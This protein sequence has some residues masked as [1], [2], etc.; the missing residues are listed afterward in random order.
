MLDV[1]WML[2]P[3]PFSGLLLYSYRSGV[4]RAA[5][6]RHLREIAEQMGVEVASYDAA[7][8]GNMW[9]VPALLDELRICDLTSAETQPTAEELLSL[10]V[11]RPAAPTVIMAPASSKH[12]RKGSNFLHVEEPR[13]TS[14]NLAKVM[15]YLA[16]TS[17]LTT[18]DLA[19][20]QEVLFGHFRRWI[21]EQ[22]HVP[23][24]EVMQEYDHAVVQ[25]SIPH[26]GEKGVGGGGFA[27]AGRSYL[28]GSLQC[29]LASDET[30]ALSQLLRALAMRK[31]RGAKD[32]DVV[33]QLLK[34]SIRVQEISCCGGRRWSGRSGAWSSASVASEVSLL[35]SVLLLRWS[36]ACTSNRTDPA[37]M[38]LLV[39]FDHFCRDF[40]NRLQDLA[41]DPLT[42]CWTGIRDAFRAISVIDESE[43]PDPAK[44]LLRSVSRHAV[45]RQPYPWIE[46][47]HRTVGRAESYRIPATSN[48]A[49]ADSDSL[50]TE[51]ASLSEVM[52]QK[53]IIQE[54]RDRFQS[55]RHDRPLLLAGPGGSGKRTI[56][57]LYAKALLC[58]GD[59]F[60]SQPC[61][62]CPSCKS[63]M[64]GSNFGYFGIDASHDDGLSHV[65]QVIRSLRYVPVTDRRVV[66]I[67]NADRSSE[68]IN[69]ALKTL[70]R[71]AAATSFILLAQDERKVEVAA[72]SR[73]AVFRVRPLLEKDVG[74]LAQRWLASIQV[75]GA[76]VELIVKSG[77][78]LPG[79]VLKLCKRVALGPTSTLEQA[80]EL[81]GLNWGV[82]ILRYWQWL[83]NGDFQ[84]A[85]AMDY[86]SGMTADDA[87]RRLRTGLRQLLAG[88]VTSEPAFLGLEVGWRELTDRLD[89]DAVKLG[90]TRVTLWDE[91]ARHWL[92]AAIIDY[93]DVIDVSLKTFRQL[94]P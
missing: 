48:S 46:K 7:T 39:E 50:N 90:Q 8:L 43:R 57:R 92:D 91:L 75:E 89:R 27:P 69:A 15:R 35:W 2:S 23:L 55:G 68:A 38:A 78:G 84:S 12:M 83:L 93:E 44:E 85:R 80:K 63:F 64:G 56:G 59:L 26:A 36:F 40:K 72:R 18:P 45:C 66:V 13:V 1:E 54:L 86:L 52:G 25:Y 17:D 67:A 22:G 37:Q 49:V 28:M 71:G 29:F 62:S 4:L 60:A 65:H 74:T 20:R 76:V 81:F 61:G 34:A 42:G 79:S 5:V 94:K 21:E 32:T 70:E 24:P 9:S 6:L 51:L 87:I 58:E 47:L 33:D 3:A 31:E 11:E 19:S 14:A 16:S 88:E 53:H 30:F 10:A 82:Q 73:S 77:R 41:A